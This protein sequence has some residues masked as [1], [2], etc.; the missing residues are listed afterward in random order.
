LTSLLS[1][2]PSS[3]L[4]GRST[5][6]VSSKARSPDLSTETFHVSTKSSTSS[7]NTH[8]HSP[9]PNAKCAKCT[10]PLFDV[11]H[12]GR[13]V[14]VPEPSSTGL[15]PRRYHADCFRCRI[16]NG[17]FEEKE[18][19][20]AVF[21]RGVR[22]AC[23][24]NCAPT[25]RTVS[26]K[27]VPVT[28]RQSPNRLSAEL[29]HASKQSPSTGSPSTTPLSSRYSA[30][31]QFAS[32]VSNPMPRFG[33]STPCPGCSQSV[34]PMERGVVPGPQGQRWHSSCLVCGGKQA[35]GRGGRRVNGQ[36][37]C[38]K[39]LDSSA[40]R[41]TGAGGVWCRDCLLLLS[42][43]LRSSP[44][45]PSP[46]KP[47]EPEPA[48]SSGQSGRIF[49]QNTGVTTL[50]RQFTG[51]ES[52]HVTGGRLSPTKQL[53]LGTPTKVAVHFTGGGSKGTIRPRPKSAIGMR[54]EGRGMFLVQQLT[55]GGGL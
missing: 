28:P 45:R 35:K 6:H 15:L 31:L 9:L 43:E 16:C 30:P 14:S 42:S 37:G 33:T 11:A 32:N 40:K 54:G 19:G 47:R 49:P 10:L 7:S 44:T 23:H 52:R 29:S 55:G 46:S 26:R 51:A 12:G 36:P 48:A 13:Y 2:S 50:A 17:L 22:G 24:L 8:A 53:G 38:G 1:S 25:E 4:S 21:V 5:K 18:A 20:R 41:D 39:R 3:S 27:S 34:S